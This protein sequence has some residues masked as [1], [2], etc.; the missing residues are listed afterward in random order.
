MQLIPTGI[1]KKKNRIVDTVDESHKYLHKWC[2]SCI[3]I[4]YEPVLG[5]Y[6][7]IFMIIMF[8]LCPGNDS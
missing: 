5:Q 8:I 1:V 3:E 7:L 2:G 4:M 6:I